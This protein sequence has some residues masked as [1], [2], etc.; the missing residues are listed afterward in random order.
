MT[1]DEA[2]KLALEAL[3]HE[4]DIGNDDAYKVERDAIK[5]ALAQPEQEP[6]GD[7]Y[8]TKDM[9]E[10]IKKLEVDWTICAS[11]SKRPTEKKVVPVFVGNTTSLQ[12]TWVGLTDEEVMEIAFN[13]DVPSLIVRTVEFKLKEKN[14]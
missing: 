6:V 2:L 9:A 13:F 1:K 3:E 12:R 7:F 4:A 8:I 11:G 5:E 10:H 14:T